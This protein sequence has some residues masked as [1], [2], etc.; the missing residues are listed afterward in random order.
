MKCYPLFK[1]IPLHF[2]ILLY[3][4]AFVFPFVL[5]CCP[6]VCLIPSVV[7][8]NS[9]FSEPRNQIW[10]SCLS[11]WWTT[12]QLSQTLSLFWP[13]SIFSMMHSHWTKLI[14]PNRFKALR[15]SWVVQDHKESLGLQENIWRRTWELA[16]KK[17]HWKDAT[18]S[19]RGSVQVAQITQC[20]SAVLPWE[21]EPIIVKRGTF[22]SFLLCSFPSS[23]LLSIFG[24]SFFLAT[25]PHPLPLR[26]WHLLSLLV[27]QLN[28]P[29]HQKT[30]Q[31]SSCALSRVKRAHRWE[32]GVQDKRLNISPFQ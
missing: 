3:F 22:C 30:I 20:V 2:S 5:N 4:L 18:R 14:F 8:F 16:Q 31:V 11:Y 6:D 21:G 19:S 23:L 15:H 28:L 1:L 32:W 7:G 9:S 10:Q 13:P 24:C 12:H 27:N 17:T 25:Q 29:E 26:L